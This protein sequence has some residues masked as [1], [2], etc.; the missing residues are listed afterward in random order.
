MRPP[1]HRATLPAASTSRADRTGEAAAR[2]QAASRPC[3][4]CARPSPIVRVAHQVST[5]QPGPGSGRRSSGGRC[6]RSRN[7]DRGI[8]ADS[9]WREDVL[10]MR[11]H[12]VQTSS[13]AQ[14]G[15]VAPPARPIPLSATAWRP[16]GQGPHFRCAKLGRSNEVC[17]ERQGGGPYGAWTIPSRSP[18][19]VY[20]LLGESSGPIPMRSASI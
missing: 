11:H 7:S 14:K 13:P 8:D 5:R 20:W 12:L 9:I 16:P 3:A 4:A 6:G 10:Q 2:W 1:P 18:S 15:A 17:Q 19:N